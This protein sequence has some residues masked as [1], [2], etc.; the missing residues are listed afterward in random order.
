MTDNRPHTEILTVPGQ[1]GQRSPMSLR[2]L[3]QELVP[4]RR[5]AAQARHVGLGPGLID[6][7]QARRVKPVLIRLPPSTPSRH[8]GTI[9]LG[10][11]QSFF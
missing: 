7:D 2:H 1:E 6:E 9:L 5:P 4:T 11:E 10:G 8:V 3:G